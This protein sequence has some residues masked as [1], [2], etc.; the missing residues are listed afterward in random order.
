MQGKTLYLECYSG[1]SGDMTVA[2]LLDLGATEEN[3][4]ST[5]E[6]LPLHGYKIKIGRV[7]KSGLDACDFDVILEEKAK[8]EEHAHGHKHEHR[9]WKDIAQMLDGAGLKPEV[10]KLS[11][12]MF[13]IVADAE[14]KVHGRPADEVHFHEVG[15]VD[16]IV[17]I[18]SVAACMEE[19]GV[20]KVL[21]SDLWEGQ[22]HVRCQHGIL[23]VPVPA[24]LQIAASHGLTLKQ[25]EQQG[26]MVTPTGAAIA[27]LSEGKRPD[28]FT[29]E[30]IGLG[31]GKRQFS[32]ANVLRAMLIKEADEQEEKLWMLESNIDDCSGE[33]LGYA[34]ECLLEAGARDVFFTSIYMKKNRPAYQLSVLCDEEKIEEMN[35]VLFRETTTIGVRRYPVKRAAL[36]RRAEEVSTAYG[37]VKVKVCFLNG[38]ELR[39]PEYES[40]KK[41][42]REHGAAYKEMYRLVREQI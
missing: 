10:L 39:Y 17:D 7:Q 38:E 30:K 26:E 16:S 35:A 20:T 1:I 15:A 37:P 24:V 2:A 4:R 8:N 42:A 40:V 5:L 32:R 34:M 36:E 27:A 14:G 6:K 12:Q 41:L 22:G 19:L 3:L 9:T 25:T 33:A 18:V 11:R 21:V 13:R 29:I 23:P 31:A 28:K